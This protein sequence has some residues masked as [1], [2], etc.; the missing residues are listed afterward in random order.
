MPFL[1][2]RG[3]ALRSAHELGLAQF[4]RSLREKYF[5][6]GGAGEK[7]IEFFSDFCGNRNSARLFPNPSAGGFPAWLLSDTLLTYRVGPAV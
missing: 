6:A 3:I 7:M 2:K 1:K 5:F 4:A